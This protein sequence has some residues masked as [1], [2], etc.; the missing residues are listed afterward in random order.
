MN[1]TTTLLIV[2]PNSRSAGEVDLSDSITLLEQAGFDILRVEP[3]DR[4]QTERLIAEHHQQVGLVIV[5]G[6]DGTISSTAAALCR[7]RLPLAILPLG[8]AN[9]LARTLEIPADVREACR[10]IVE[11]RRLHVDL[12]EVNGHYFFNVANIG[13]GVRI[14]HE[15]TPEVKK[16]W[17][18]FSY[19]KA[20]VTA[21]SRNNEFRATLIIDGQAHRV[22]SMQMAIGN[23]RYYGGGNVIDEDADIDDGLLA[24]YS[25]RPQG[26]WELLTLAPLLRGGRQHQ[27]ERTFNARGKR[28]E[29]QTP[30]PMEVHADGEPVT[31]TPATFKVNERALQVVVPASRCRGDEA[32]SPAA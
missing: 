26:F 28:I 2:N 13:L 9:D 27:T 31:R 23:G 17:G 30:R 14:T 11:N 7:Y 8:T 10:V 1:P 20:L 18:I 5:A 15:L 16:H 4:E 19:L 3:R 22:R 32:R 24:F 25:L 6:G 12:G 21:L 29:V